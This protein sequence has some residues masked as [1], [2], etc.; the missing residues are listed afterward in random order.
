MDSGLS[1]RQGFDN[2]DNVG[3]LNAI[4]FAVIWCAL[5]GWES[6]GLHMGETS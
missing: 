4:T 1:K 5:R 2:F 6:A 3:K